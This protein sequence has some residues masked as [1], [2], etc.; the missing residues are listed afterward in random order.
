MAETQTTSD[1]KSSF[2]IVPDTEAAIW[3]WQMRRVVRRLLRQ[4]LTE[5]EHTLDESERLCALS[6][7]QQNLSYAGDDQSLSSG[8]ARY[9]PSGSLS[10]SSRAGVP[11]EHGH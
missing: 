10:I 11:P 2:R 5:I 3:G 1:P 7:Q 8:V 9:W 4:P 6:R